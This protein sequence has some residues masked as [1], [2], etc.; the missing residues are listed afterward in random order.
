MKEHSLS[1]ASCEKKYR[2][3]ANGLS[4]AEVNRS[5]EINGS[6]VLS[7]KKQKSLFKKILSALSD[8]MLVI[9]EFALIITLGIY[10]N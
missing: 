5:R 9:L 8:P 2:S 3:G 10:F 6:N 7:E 1:I 4:K